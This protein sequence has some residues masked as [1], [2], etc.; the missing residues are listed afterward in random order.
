MED[1]RQFTA[2][3]CGQIHVR[4]EAS[5]DEAI[6]KLASAQHGVVARRQLLGLGVSPSALDHRLRHGRLRIAH[7]GVYSV[8]HDALAFRGRVAAAVLAASSRRPGEGNGNVTRAAASHRTAAIL[9]GLLGEGRGL[10]HVS[11]TERRRRLP[12]VAVYRAVLPRD[13]LGR[14]AGIPVTTVPRTLLD[15][16]RQL[17]ARSLRRLVKH[18][19]YLGLVDM[20]A[21]SAILAKYPRRRGRRALAEI[22]RSVLGGRSRSDLEDR[23]IEFCRRFELPAP[24]TNVVIEIGGTPIEIDCVWRGERIAI[25]LDGYEGHGTRLAFEDDR[26][27]DRAVAAAGWLPIRITSR[28][29]DSRPR[30]LAAELLAILRTR[31]SGDERRFASLERQ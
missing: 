16:S 6:A 30:R 20:S 1:E 23:F 9:W 27:R 7:P 31:S 11:A 24:E 28:Q 21:I 19:E 3:L 26:A 17:E 5:D 29:V 12:G 2:L 14:A 25:E 15:L 18:A 4:R 10:V 22:E 13:E 8:G